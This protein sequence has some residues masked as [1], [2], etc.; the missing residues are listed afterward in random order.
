MQT[1]SVLIIDDHPL[2]SSSYKMAFEHISSQD[3]TLKFD[4]KIVGN[5][6]LLNISFLKLRLGI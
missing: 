6:D 3:A 5:C 2:I 1:K 4:V